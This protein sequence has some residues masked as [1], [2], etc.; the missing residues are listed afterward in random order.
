MNNLAKLSIYSGALLS[1]VLPFYDFECH[2]FF[3]VEKSSV[4]RTKQGQELINSISLAQRSYFAEH[5][6]FTWELDNLGLGIAAETEK[7]RYRILEP[8]TP[9]QFPGYHKPKLTGD[10]LFIMAQSNL[11][12]S[13]DYL[14]AVFVIADRDNRN[15]LNTKHQI[16]QVNYRHH[17]L[18]ALPQIVNHQIICPRG[19]IPI[20]K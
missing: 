6:E 12:N 20:T 1:L 14:A 5:G 3:P 9:V 4:G 15:K 2:C 17:S 10:R 18:S 16:C 11:P 19:T 8:M 7:Y 13:P